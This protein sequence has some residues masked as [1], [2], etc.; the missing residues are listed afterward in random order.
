MTNSDYTF[1]TSGKIDLS[2]YVGGMMQFA[3]RYTSSTD[4]AGTW[5]IKNVVVE[6]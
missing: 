4:A 5:E 2:A 1:V 3:F 6:R